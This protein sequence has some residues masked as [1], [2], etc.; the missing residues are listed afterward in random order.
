LHLAD[1]GGFS[2]QIWR[3]RKKSSGNAETGAES[4]QAQ[5]KQE[6]AQGEKQRPKKEMKPK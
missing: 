6:A 4:T 2:H 3:I 5:D 1:S